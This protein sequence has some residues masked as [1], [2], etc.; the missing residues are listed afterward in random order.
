[1]SST[2]PKKSLLLLAMM[3]W[4]AIEGCKARPVTISQRDVEAVFSV[5]RRFHLLWD[6]TSQPV[7]VGST[8]GPHVYDFRDLSFVL[9]DTVTMLPV[10]QIPQLAKRFPPDALTF[11]EEGNTVYPVFSFSNEG[12]NRDGRARIVPDT[13]WYQHI[14][15]ADEWLK[16]PLAFNTQSSQ[17]NMVVV[18]TTYVKGIPT[19]TSADTSSVASG[20][21]GLP[22][23][24][25]ARRDAPSESPQR[26]SL[27]DPGGCGN[28]DRLGHVAA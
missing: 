23:P 3:S 11:N 4:L 14:V 26:V 22:M 1:M 15:P 19:L 13:E 6:S 17:S 20:R 5:G 7:N 8:G 12:F 9:Y 27:L 16:L 25:D 21:I 28:P 10:A 18:D 24:A 2:R